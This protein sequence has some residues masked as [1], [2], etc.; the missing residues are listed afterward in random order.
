VLQASCDVVA[1]DVQPGVFERPLVQRSEVRL[2]R[3][4]LEHRGVIVAQHDTSALNRPFDDLSSERVRVEAEA[5][6]ALLAAV[7]D[8]VLEWIGS[9]TSTS[10]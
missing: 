2:R 8:K 3:R 1:D 5:L 6:V 4:E 9:G 10:R 7:E